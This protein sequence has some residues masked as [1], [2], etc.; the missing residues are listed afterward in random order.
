[1][2]WLQDVKSKK[3]RALEKRKDC[4]YFC[5]Y[6]SNSFEGDIQQLE[7]HQK[8]GKHEMCKGVED[9]FDNELY[10]KRLKI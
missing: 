9:K 3:G 8:V 7:D 5:G 1:M 6:C 2:S 4:G 10:L